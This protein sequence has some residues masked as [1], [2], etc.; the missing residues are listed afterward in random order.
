MVVR[1]VRI[2]MLIAAAFTGV[3]AGMLGMFLLYRQIRQRQTATR[4]LQSVT[5][6]VSDIV[7]SAMDPIITVDEEQRI[8]VFNAAAEKVF[9]WPRGAVLGQ[10]LDKLLPERFREGIA[11]I[12][13]ASAAG[14]ERADG[15]RHDRA[16]ACVPMARNSRSKPRSRSIPRMAGNSSR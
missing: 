10:P 12:S 11:S 14:D 1:L 2:E 9:R 5:A 15:W 8:V 13:S 6:R 4:D 16:A 3:A 7:E